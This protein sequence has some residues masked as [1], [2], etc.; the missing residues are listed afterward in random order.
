MDA[1][2]LCRHFQDVRKVVQ[3]R[4]VLAVSG[5]LVQVKQLWNLLTQL[6]GFVCVSHLLWWQV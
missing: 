1:S 3:T 2:K 6:E 5:T 4:L